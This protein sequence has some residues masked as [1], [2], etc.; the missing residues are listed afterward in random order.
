[1]TTT[2][3]GHGEGRVAMIARRHNVGGSARR[4]GGLRAPQLSGSR[5][6]A[7]EGDGRRRARRQGVVT[8]RVKDHVSDHG[9][10]RTIGG[11]REGA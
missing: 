5:C 6:G 10:E 1:M 4:R 8:T 3:A 11:A 2:T 7:L 9:A